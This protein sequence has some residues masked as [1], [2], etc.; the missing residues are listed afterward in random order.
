MNRLAKLLPIF[1]YI[2]HPIFISIYGALFYFLISPNTQYFAKGQIYLIL[3]QVAI[4]TLLLPLSLYFL[5]VSLGYISS[6]TEA[7]LKER[8]LP[9]TIQAVLLFFLIRF[10]QNLSDLPE[11]YYFFLGGFFSSIIAF[12]C[13]LAKFKASL[14][15]I[16]ISSLAA[17]IYG[18][19]LF[20][21]LSLINSVAFSVICIGFVASSR[22]YM[23]SHTNV[24][25][26]I[27]LLI[28]L[29][30]QTTLWYFWL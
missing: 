9:I 30:P 22:L 10:N 19:M 21:N 28:G 29:I 17:F 1:S 14:H 5:M 4:L 20:Y 25:L 3:F 18:L 23:K 27:G 12:L 15:M 13:V 7:S 16:G 8:R 6:F 26:F 2:F 11:L 24:E